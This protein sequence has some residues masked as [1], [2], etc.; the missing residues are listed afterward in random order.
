M[1]ATQK[2][3]RPAVLMIARRESPNT[4]SATYS[5]LSM[6]CQSGVAIK[7]SNVTVDSMTMTNTESDG[8][9]SS[10]S[11]KPAPGGRN[12][13]VLTRMSVSPNFDRTPNAKAKGSACVS[14]VLRPKMNMPVHVRMENPMANHARCDGMDRPSQISS[15]HAK[16][17]NKAIPG[18]T[19]TLCGH[20]TIDLRGARHFD[21]IRSHQPN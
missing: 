1:N 12:A 5:A 16:A 10:L 20:L 15:I 17:M 21:A 3:R 13:S 6:R 14:H 19:P 2:T 7:P 4:G 9:M 11:T 8:L 18:H